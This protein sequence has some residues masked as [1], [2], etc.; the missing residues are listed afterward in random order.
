MRRKD[1]AKGVI[2][3]PYHVLQFEMMTGR[4]FLMQSI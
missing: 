1:R 4:G 2:R 3:G